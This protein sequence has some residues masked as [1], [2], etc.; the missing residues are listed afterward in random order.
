M[1]N[2]FLYHKTQY[3]VFFIDDSKKLLFLNLKKSIVFRPAVPPALQLS[4]YDPVLKKISIGSDDKDF[5]CQYSYHS[6]IGNL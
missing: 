4:G 5:P 1:C 6:C 2:N 3:Y